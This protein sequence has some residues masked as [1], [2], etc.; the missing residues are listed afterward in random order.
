VK[1]SACVVETHFGVQAC[2]YA[3]GTSPHTSSRGTLRSVPSFA[4]AAEYNSHCLLRRSSCFYCEGQ[5]SHCLT[6]G[7]PPLVSLAE[8]GKQRC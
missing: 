8:E 1:P 4:K 2:V 6:G 7:F 5:A 3:R